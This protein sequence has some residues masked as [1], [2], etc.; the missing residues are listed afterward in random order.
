M[1]VSS[2]GT[3]GR[4]GIAM[5]GMS[6]GAAISSG[7]DIVKVGDAKEEVERLENSICKDGRLG[8]GTI[9][10]GWLSSNLPKGGNESKA[11]DL[12]DEAELGVRGEPPPL[13]EGNGTVALIHGRFGK[14]GND[15]SMTLRRSDDSAGEWLGF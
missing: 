3:S 15:R 12:R 9:P 13:V 6:D 10:L 2:T 7:L 4:D 11:R 1:G 14:S 8:R 5:C